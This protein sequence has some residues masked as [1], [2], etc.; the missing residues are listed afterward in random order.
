MTNLVSFYAN[1][2]WLLF[3]TIVVSFGLVW[4][5]VKVAQAKNIAV[6]SNQMVSLMNHKKGIVVDIRKE[7]AFNSNHILN[8]IN[9]AS[10][11]T[12]NLEGILAKQNSNKKKPVIF[13]D[14]NGSSSSS[15]ASKFTK[16]GYE[17]YYLEG[18]INSWINASLP[19]VQQIAEKK[20][21]KKMPEIVMYTKARCPYCVNAKNLL[22]SKG[23]KY[24][25]I[26]VDS[27][28][29]KI[30][31]MVK[32]SNR[33]TVPQIFINGKHIGGYDD[34]KRF[35]ESGQLDKLISQ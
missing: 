1:N 12:N 19:T 31:E 32:L 30:D 27:D 14:T 28:Q 17:A 13:V 10:E 4:V 11:N 3:S 25:E 6:D 21:K 35:Q 8:S 15:L 34:L 24:K 29:E 5:E 2:L 9:F 16:I 7:S 26:S 23:L 33:R 22:N 20:V 18:G